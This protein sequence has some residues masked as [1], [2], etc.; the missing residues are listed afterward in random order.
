MVWNKVVFSFTAF[1]ILQGQPKDVNSFFR[2]WGCDC[3]NRSLQLQDSI[4]ICNKVTIF[5]NLLPNPCSFFPGDGFAKL[6]NLGQRGSMYPISR[7]I[8]NHTGLRAFAMVPSPCSARILY[9][10]GLL[11]QL[12]SAFIQTSLSQ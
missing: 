8:S 7:I 11:P 3:P 12:H 1:H 9:L 4:W 6:S 5:P 10:H 2:K